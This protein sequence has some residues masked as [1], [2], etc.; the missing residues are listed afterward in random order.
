[1]LSTEVSNNADGYRLSTYLYKYSDSRGQEEGLD[2]RWKCALWDFNMAWGNTKYYNHVSNNMWHYDINFRND[3]KNDKDW[4]PFYWGKLLQDTK[5]VELLNSRWKQYRSTNYSNEA[6]ESQIDSLT[7][8]LQIGGGLMRNEKAWKI[9]SSSIWGV[10]Y[11]VDSYQEEIS[12]IKN[13][14]EGRLYFIDKNIGN[15][16]TGMNS[17]GGK[18]NEAFGIY[19]IQG[20]KQEVEPQKGIFLYR[21]NGKVTKVIK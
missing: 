6:I 13:W 15:V 9:F 11:N 2:T 8:L 5:F 4:V 20:I 10:G 18:F 19:S 7:T 1:M 21:R 14:I 12:Y 3:F 17:L 16:T